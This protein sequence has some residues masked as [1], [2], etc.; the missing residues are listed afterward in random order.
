VLGA[1]RV[2]RFCE[3]RVSHEGTR[4]DD[5]HARIGKPASFG[6]NHAAEVDL[7]A[8]DQVRLPVETQ[9]EDAHGPITRGA[10]GEVLAQN[11]V[12]PFGADLAQR[13]PPGSDGIPGRSGGEDGETL[14]FDGRNHCRSVG[15]GDGVAGGLGGLGGAGDRDQR[16]DVAAAGA[17]EREEDAHRPAPSRAR[18]LS[19]CLSRIVGAI[20][21]CA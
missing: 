5:E 15:E 8:H 11:V 9:R 4:R 1:Q 18:E 14:G 6:C 2:Q 7:V 10:A 17:D 3:E 20:D 13:D 19:A 12:L 21:P 16:I